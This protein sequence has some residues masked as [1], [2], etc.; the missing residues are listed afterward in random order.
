MFISKTKTP[1]PSRQDLACQVVVDLDAKAAE[2]TADLA[3]QEARAAEV[4]RALGEALASNPSDS[5]TSMSEPLM[6]ERAGADLL[7]AALA[8]LERRRPALVIAIA[9]ARIQML[10][11]EAASLVQQAEQVEAAARKHWESL[12]GLEFEGRPVGVG[13]MPSVQSK[14]EAL[15]A[16][17][18]ILTSEA[19]LSQ[20]GKAVVGQSYLENYKTAR[21]L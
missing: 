15:R 20:I 14:S 2:L 6:R 21:G 7:K 11:C 3:R 18:E 9:D 19:A 1:P 13:D 16:R 8:A 4:E 12:S 10:E 5:L 17:A